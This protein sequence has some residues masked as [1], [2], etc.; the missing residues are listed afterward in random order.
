MPRYYAHIVALYEKQRA[1]SYVVEFARL[2]LQFVG[3]K[4]A[5]ADILRTELQS[6]LFNGA[7]A[8][9]QF[10]LAHSTLVAMRD[11][12]LQYSCLQ[13]LVQ[14]MCDNLHN[15]ELVELPFPGLQNAIDEILERKCRD[16]VDVV[17]GPPY[18]QVLYAWRIR[19]NDYRGAAA[20]LLD[21]LQKL[22]QL[23]E[24]DGQQLTINGSSEAIGGMDGNGGDVLETPVTRQYLMLINVLSCVDPKQAWV[25]TEAPA[26]T[27]NGTK[28][29]AAKKRKIVTLADVRKEYQG[30]LDRIAAIQN[31][32]FGFAA[33]DEMEIL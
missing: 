30:E 12:A 28:A 10:E 4:T 5:D 3:N 31:N 16:A 20:V 8:I 25:A 23:G 29:P 7:T 21:R 18:H 24:G 1:Y 26:P 33:G 6:R 32:Q 2:A 22:R 27:A 15:A 11:H 19:H 17:T 13:K 9:S 14:R